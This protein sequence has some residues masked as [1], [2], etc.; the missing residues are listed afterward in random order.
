MSPRYSQTAE[1]LLEKLTFYKESIDF[2]V[3]DLT[4]PFPL[5]QL[6]K[7]DKRIIQWTKEVEEEFDY[8]MSEHQCSWAIVAVMKS[9]LEDFNAF[10]NTNLVAK[11]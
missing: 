9:T 10:N 1:R 7:T 2:E 6:S 8:Q 5:D 4:K 11:T 3:I